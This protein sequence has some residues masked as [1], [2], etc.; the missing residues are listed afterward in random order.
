MHIC[1]TIGFGLKVALDNGEP[2]G[3]SGRADG[4]AVYLKH[5]ATLVLAHV[6]G[7]KVYG[8]SGITSWEGRTGAFFDM[9]NACICI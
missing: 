9:Y 6:L 3:S 1:S 5:G 7:P 4:V 8:G 2:D